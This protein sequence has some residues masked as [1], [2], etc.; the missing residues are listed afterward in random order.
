MM[1]SLMTEKVLSSNKAEYIDRIPLKRIA[2]PEEVAHSIL[3][4]AS[5]RADY[6]TGATLDV[7]GGLLMH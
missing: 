1:Y 2:Q 5:N 4:L 6:I 7:S 3:F